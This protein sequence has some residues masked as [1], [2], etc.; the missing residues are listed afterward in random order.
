MALLACFLVAHA[1]GM[2]FQFE[3]IKNNL[4]L[5]IHWELTKGISEMIN[6]F[7]CLQ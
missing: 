3:R 5:R 4:T 1:P 2:K 6:C 7:V